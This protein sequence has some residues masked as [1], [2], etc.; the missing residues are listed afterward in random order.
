VSPAGRTRLARVVA[1]VVVAAGL[2]G[3]YW[4]HMRSGL[5]LKPETLHAWLAEVGPAAPLLFMAIVAL[6][7]LL[8]LPSWVVLVAAG[9]LFGTVGGILL[10]TVGGTLGAL[11]AFL[12]GRTLG[13]EAV[14]RRLSGAVARL[15]AYMGRH[16]PVWLAGFTALPVTPLTPTYYAAGLTS[17]RTFAFALG[18]AAGLVPRSAL[19]AFFGESLIAADVK[20]IAIAA[21]ALAV[22][23]GATLLVRRRLV[24]RSPAPH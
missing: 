11:L 24:G 3:A 17:M 7:P 20:G 2:C 13:R 9:I 12:L 8:L 4:L 5:E 21:V 14:E 15:D 22:G 19:Y 1:V 10:G 23:I 18:A 6:R 16:G